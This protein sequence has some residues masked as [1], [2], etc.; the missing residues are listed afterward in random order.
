MGNSADID[1]ELLSSL[2]LPSSRCRYRRCV[3]AVVKAVVGNMH[4]AKSVDAE[5]VDFVPEDAAV[6]YSRLT[7]IVQPEW[8]T[9]GTE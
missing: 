1:R 3:K 7:A 4:E 8:R 6:L 5:T 9:C 2:L